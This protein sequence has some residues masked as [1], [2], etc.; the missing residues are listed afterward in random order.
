M[1]GTATAAA[2]VLTKTIDQRTITVIGTVAFAAGTGHTDYAVGGLALDLSGTGLG[3]VAPTALGVSFQSASGALYSYDA[4]AKKIKNFSAVN[5][6]H[7][8]SA[9]SDFAADVPTFTAVVLR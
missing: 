3:V 8:A 7:T 5:T 1:A 4:S 9:A 2:T 6:E